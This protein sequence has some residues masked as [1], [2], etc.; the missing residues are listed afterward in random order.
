MLQNYKCGICDSKPDQLSHHRSHIATQKHKDK[1]CIFKLQLQSMNNN[2]LEEKYNNTNIEVIIS[3]IETIHIIKKKE[4]TNM[5]NNKTI[6]GNILWNLENN[7]DTNQNYNAIKNK[8]NSI[9]KQCHNLLY[10]PGGSIV[11]IKA[12]NDIMR[13]LCLKILQRQFND[14]NSELWEKCNQVKAES[15]LSDLQFN[16]YKTYCMDLKEIIKKD[17]VIKEWRIFVNKFLSKVFPSIYYEDDNKFNCC[18]SQ[19]IIELIKIINTLDINDEFKDAFST[20]CGDIHESF[21]AYDGK[22]SGAKDLGQYFT[23]RRL[24]HLMFHGIGLDKLTEPM[25]DITIYDPCMGTGGFLTRLFK[26]G[27]ILPENIYGCETEIDTIK[28]GHMSMVLTTGNSRNNI[29][30]CN[31]LCEN[32]FILDKK[33]SAIITNPPF[34]TNMN[35][36]NLKETFEKEF[37]DSPVKFEDIYP[38]NTNNGA[39]LFV[40]HCVYMLA[41]GGVCAIVLPDGE[42]FEGNSKWSKTFRKWLSE[43]V[44]ILT[45]LKVASGTF[46]RAGVKTNVVVFTKDGPTQNIKFMETPKE[47][48]VVKDMFTISAEELKTAGYSLDVG[49]YLVEETDNYDVPMVALRDLFTIEYGSKNPNVTD[50]DN[51]YPSISGGSKISKYTNEWNIPAETILIARSGS[52]GS[53]NKF[54]TNCLMGSYGFFLNKKNEDYNNEYIYQYLKFYQTNI[55]NLAR[56]TAVKNLNREKLYDFKIP[57]PSLEVQQQIVDEL[58]QIE[59]SIETIESRITQLKREKDQYKKYGRKA[60]IRELLKDSEEKMLGEVCELNK[61]SIKSQD[62]YNEIKY[63]ALSNINEGYV[64]NIKTINFKDKPSRASRKCNIGDV[65]LGGTRPNLRNHC[66]ITEELHSDNL[67]VSTAFIVLTPIDV[68]SKYIYNLIMSDDITTL[69]VSNCTSDPPAI[70]ITKASSIK[71]PIPSQEVQQQCIALFEEKEKFIQSIDD[72]INQET[73]YTD[74]LKKLAKDVISS[75]C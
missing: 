5:N 2:E 71:I 10:G 24:I 69:L 45:I 13:I 70:N 12:Q 33:F 15:N 27:N 35:Y 75:F 72:K 25:E 22:S 17:D 48:N 1:R 28:F 55:E 67:I 9:I 37:P 34:G 19:C 63:I 21:R 31:S 57:L 64:E 42:L 8:L 20:T 23:P 66:I 26:M 52:C 49:E 51:V 46:E 18:K 39:C 44:N 73:D 54:N 40:Q 68:L 50:N 62:N 14:E 61:I 53:V 47:C 7:Q 60:E 30:K 4:N 65:L 41:E 74:T 58:S 56:G 38:L 6:S 59:T 43:K 36:K 11:G 29:I 32:K 16:R 3:K